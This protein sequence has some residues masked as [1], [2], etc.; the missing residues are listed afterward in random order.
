MAGTREGGIK[1]AAKN[2]ASDPDFYA[3]I[4][5]KGGS[6]GRTGGFA[7]LAIHDPETHRIASAR[8]G[9]KSRRTKVST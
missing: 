3:K 9:R 5:R 8:G 1:A 4:G 2:K 7:Y 6:K